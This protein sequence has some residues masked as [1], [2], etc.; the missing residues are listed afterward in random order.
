[1]GCCLLG[2]AVPAA[3]ADDEVE[4][5]TRAKFDRLARNRTGYGRISLGTAVGR[6]LRFNNPYRLETQ[7]GDTGESLSL[8]AT[9]FDTGVT[10]SFGDPHG[11]QHGGAL[12]LSFALQGVSQQAIA[13]AYQ[14]SYV[15]L[16]PLLLSAR[17]GPSLLTSPTTNLGGELAVGGTLMVT[18]VWAITA[19]LI[20]DL[21]YGAGTEA[22][23]YTVYPILSGQLGLA[24]EFEV[25]P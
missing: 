12:H 2:P 19:D 21:F 8:T 3:A 20:G 13:A 10:M 1:V 24:A 5:K 15:G 11:W 6:G 25:L 4:P 17:V 16:R 22:A 23:R 9:Y 18:G 14:L 7:L